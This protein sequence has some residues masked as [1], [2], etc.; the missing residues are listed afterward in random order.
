MGAMTYNENLR[1]VAEPAAPAERREAV[2]ASVSDFEALWLAEALRDYAHYGDHPAENHASIARAYAEYIDRQVRENERKHV[3]LYAHT[4]DAA[5]TLMGALFHDGAEQ[6]LVERVS[7]KLADLYVAHAEGETPGEP[8]AVDGVR[9]GTV[10]FEDGAAEEA[11]A[12]RQMEEA[13]SKAIAEVEE[14]ANT[15]GVN[16]QP[17]PRVDPRRGHH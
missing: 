12:M 13:E 16:N 15:L 17:T 11:E 2:S 8:H 14:K 10:E 9:G 7:P 1:H 6:T 5:D 4:D 3:T